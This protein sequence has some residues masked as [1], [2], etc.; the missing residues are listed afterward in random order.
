M[1]ARTAT[2]ERNQL[3]N[4]FSAT[5]SRT[6]AWKLIQFYINYDKNANSPVVLLQKI[7]IVYHKHYEGAA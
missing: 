1:P 3:P 6:L 5:Q 2:A 4:G 7:Q